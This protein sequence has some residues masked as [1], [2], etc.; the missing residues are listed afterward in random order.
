MPP[1]MVRQ[2]AEQQATSLPPP[3]PSP[4]LTSRWHRLWSPGWPGICS[5]PP[6]PPRTQPPPIPGVTVTGSQTAS[7]PPSFPK[8]RWCRLWSQVGQVRVPPSPPPCLLIY[9]RCYC[10]RKPS[11]KPC[12][13]T[14]QKV[15]GV[16]CDH[17]VGQVCF[18]SSP[19][20]LSTP[21][22]TVTGSQTASLPP[23]LPKGRWCRLWSPG[24][25]VSPPTPLN[26]RCYSHMGIVDIVLH[27]CVTLVY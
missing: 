2:E 16:D 26:T 27:V 15:D 25:Y 21:G 13:I 8:G 11:S 14:P 23:S 17:L 3:S 1:Y 7:L 5:P 12:T 24:W 4:L 9:T 22:V 20:P 19:L 10:H 18:P 6:N